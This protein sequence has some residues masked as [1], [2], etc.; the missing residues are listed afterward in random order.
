MAKLTWDLEDALV[1]KKKLLEG[2]V[3]SR[4]ILN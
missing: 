1:D 4:E 2:D 3:S